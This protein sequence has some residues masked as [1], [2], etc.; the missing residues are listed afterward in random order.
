LS[1]AILNDL[2]LIEGPDGLRVLILNHPALFAGFDV[3]PSAHQGLQI[4][5]QVSTGVLTPTPPLP[6]GVACTRGPRF[7]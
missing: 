4:V 3:L 1:E 7:T 5:C 2:A 6:P